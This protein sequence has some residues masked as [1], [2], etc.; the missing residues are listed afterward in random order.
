MDLFHRTT[1]ENVESILAFGLLAR[2]SNFWKSA[3]GCIYLSSMPDTGFGEELL[4]ISGVPK[5]D[6]ITQVSSWEFLYWGDI[7]PE[8]ILRQEETGAGLYPCNRYG[9]W[10]RR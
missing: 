8:L 10:G 7:P 4:V 1:P 3:G 9:V 6:K 5:Q 2:R